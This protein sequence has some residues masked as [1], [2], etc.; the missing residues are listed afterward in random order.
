MIRVNEKRYLFVDQSRDTAAKGWMSRVYGCRAEE[1]GL[2]AKSKYE[3][4]RYLGNLSSL[5]NGQFYWQAIGLFS[6]K[7]LLTTFSNKTSEH[8]NTN[9]YFYIRS[10]QE[11]SMYLLHW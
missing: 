2:L 9:F 5:G 3:N 4:I 10:Y 6:N 1:R 11:K 7:Y 8:G